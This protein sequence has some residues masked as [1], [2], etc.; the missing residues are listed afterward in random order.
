VNGYGYPY[1]E[2]G[3]SSYHYRLE[4][5]GVAS[6]IGTRS[7][8]WHHFKM[9]LNAGFVRIYL[10]GRWVADVPFSNTITKVQLSYNNARRAPTTVLFD[11]LEISENIDLAVSPASRS[12]SNASANGQSVSVLA[13]I[14][15]TAN[16]TA[17]WITI[18]EG[19]AGDNNGTVTY[20]VP[21][22]T[23]AA[24]S[25]TI[26]VSGGGITQTFTVNQAAVSSLVI[27]P[28]SRD[29]ANT[30]ASGQTIG[31]TANIPW[32]A[33]KNAEWI[34]ITGG[35]SGANNGTVTYSVAANPG[36][37]RSGTITVSGGGITRTFTVNQAAVNSL[38]INPT[39]RSLAD[40]A[41]GGQTV[42]VTANVSWSA[43]E[44]SDWI[45]IN[46]GASGTGNGTLTYSVMENRGFARSAT[47][48]FV[49][50]GITRSFVI[51]QAAC[52]ILVPND[53][54]G[55]RS[56]DLGFYIP[57]GG[58]WQLRHS[59]GGSKA[60]A[61]GYVGTIPVTGD[62]DG[63]GIIDYG[64]Y[65]APGGNWYLMQSRAGFKTYT[66]GYQGTVPVVGDFDGDRK[67]DIGFYYASDGN[68]HLMQSRAGL[69]TY[70]FGYQ[71]T[72]PVVGDF[73]GD[74]KSDVGCYYAPGGNWYLMQSRAGF[75]TYT[76][77]YQGTVP[78]V[79]DFDGDRKS[80]IG[81][82]YAPGGNWYL[83][84]SRAG[85]KTHTFGYRGTVPVVG[86]YDGDGR[87]DFGCY[88]A[89]GIPGNVNPGTWFIMQSQSGFLR[90]VWGAQGSI[91][92]G[93]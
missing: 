18:T 73:D 80:D 60:N 86:D 3:N 26:T 32:A 53:F 33:S 21:A 66:F 75:K 47:I 9:V 22:N 17:S 72:V 67:S 10:D 78:V 65:Y 81:C 77:G 24:R 82:Y 2:T 49:G 40:T 61:F 71:G 38:V 45:T 6:S 44:T 41:V 52:S 84:Q 19:A 39:S 15:W 83:M 54:D 51:N 85:F 43:S 55:D 14:P 42:G 28:T 59:S 46:S 8:G 4:H 74:G 57:S 92:L 48:S 64:C 12:H 79:G 87:M 11:K 90:T 88:D 89:T 37:A 23:G 56:S 29:H 68:W 7:I 76:F 69:K 35:A 62:F 20:S 16:K 1:N 31:V 93:K 70:T 36:A 58:Q 91:P 13:N 30:A 63:D 25:G 50:G 5:G 27:N 34:T